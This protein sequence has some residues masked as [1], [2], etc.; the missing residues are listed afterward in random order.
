MPKYAPEKFSTCLEIDELGDVDVVVEYF[1]CKGSPA[2]VSGP[3][4]LC[5]P[6][7]PDEVEI[8]RVL[9]ADGKPVGHL[10]TDEDYELLEQR[11]LDEVYAQ[12][13]QDHADAQ[14]DARMDRWFD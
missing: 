11:V 7:D 14:A 3:P 10:L 5:D 1:F 6:G 12:A 2:R 8:H 9:N 4:E 13:E